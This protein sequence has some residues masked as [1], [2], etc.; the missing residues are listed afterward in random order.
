MSRAAEEAYEKWY[1]NHLEECKRDLVV[2]T[3]VYRAKYKEIE[4]G[5]VRSIRRGTWKPT[6][7]SSYWVEEPNGEDY[8]FYAAFGPNAE[9][10]HFDWDGQGTQWK[11]FFKLSDA[12]K[13]LVK[14]AKRSAEECRTEAIK[15]D[16]IVEKYE[17]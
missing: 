1:K 13:D 10:K 6:G 12:Q 5:I 2:G 7:F 14:K 15:W 16:K 8:Q 3:K 11:W 9:N 4:E 17:K